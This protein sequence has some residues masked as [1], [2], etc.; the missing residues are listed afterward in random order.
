MYSEPNCPA[1][2]RR[3]EL[4][5]GVPYENFASSRGARYDPDDPLVWMRGAAV[6]RWSRRG[7]WCAALE[8]F[9]R[10]YKINIFTLHSLRNFLCDFEAK[11]RRHLRRIGSFA[12]TKVNASF[13]F[14]HLDSFGVHQRWGLGF[15]RHIILNGEITTI[16]GEK[17][18]TIFYLL[19]KEFQRIESA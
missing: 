12:N 4:P 11:A 17:K 5:Y 19:A 1:I 18:L 7:Y 14:L 6:N 13:A 10:R 15:R 2:V 9:V 16:E 3:S 8:R